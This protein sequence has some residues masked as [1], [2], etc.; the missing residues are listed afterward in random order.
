MNR[1]S[2]IRDR[3]CA[4]FTLVELTAGMVA[5]AVLALTVG[6]MLAFGY[7][8]WKACKAD[9]DLQRDGAVVERLMHWQLREAVRGRVSVSTNNVVSYQDVNGGWHSFLR[10]GTALRYDGRDVITTVTGFSAVS[11]ERTVEITI[12]LSNGQRQD[13]IRT[14]IFARN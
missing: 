13:E 6:A 14:R 11:N 4:G 10:S 3:S 12:Q 8:G 2:L 9:A 5:G 1:L 7:K